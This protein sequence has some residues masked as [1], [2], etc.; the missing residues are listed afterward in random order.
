MILSGIRYSNNLMLSRVDGN[1]RGPKLALGK[2]F[3]LTRLLPKRKPRPVVVKVP[4]KVLDKKQQLKYHIHANKPRSLNVANVPSNV[5]R[6]VLH[7]SIS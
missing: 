4:A 7:P 5:Q 3:K 2:I 1:L 6:D